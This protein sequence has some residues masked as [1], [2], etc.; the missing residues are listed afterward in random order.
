MINPRSLIRALDKHWEVIERI[1]IQSR[2]Q[3]AHE[4]DGLLILL[5]KVYVNETT[6]QHIERLQQLVNAELL[7][8]L[9]HSNS[10]QL[11][12]NVRHFV[13]GLLHEHELGLSDI[14]KVRIV[15]IK[16]GLEQLQQAMQNRD[17]AALQQGAVRIDSQLRQIMQQLD[18]DA[19]AIQDIAER[20]KGNDERMP[21]AR[22]YREVLEAYDRYVL[23]M[24]ELMDTGSGGNFYPLL[25][26]AELVLEALIQQ[27][28]IQGGLYSHQLML[29]Q[30]GF[31]V[32]DLRQ[33]GLIVLK[34]CTNTLMPL[35]EE[36][37]R[38]NQLSAAIGHLLGEVRKKG[39]RRTFPAQS[40][41]V[42][43]KERAFSV[44][45]GPELLSLMEQVR[46]YQPKSVEFPELM[47]DETLLQLEQINEEAIRRHFYQSLP[48]A[49]L[50]RWLT[51][52]YG[53]Y[54]DV[55]VLR[56]YH[57]LIRLPDI[58]ATPNQDETTLT[59]KAVS[60]R[61]HSHAIESL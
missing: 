46:H 24:T 4:R 41:P 1:V 51:Q 48:L 37:R 16:T 42:W 5:A 15:D 58:T 30:V 47:T 27:L 57:K 6:E 55:T 56:L 29:R 34:Q 32:R 59:L 40:L 49:D 38:H 22:R 21:L 36:I 50:M 26:E 11:N 13:A 23:P 60:I 45:I 25:E 28:A 3:I 12:E 7:I 53:H 20:A 9:A 8:E 10:L 43:R 14:L 18:Q 2:D 33:T 61:L 35:R 52:H 44:A 39:L 31:H 54:Q 19:H 17:M